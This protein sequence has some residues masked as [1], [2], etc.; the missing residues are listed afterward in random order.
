MSEPYFPWIIIQPISWRSQP[1][2]FLFWSYDH[3]EARMQ[4]L[5]TGEVAWRGITDED[6]DRNCLD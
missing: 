3:R 5:F 2:R 4:H 6:L 1:K